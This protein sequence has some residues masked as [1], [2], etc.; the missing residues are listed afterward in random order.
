MEARARSSALPVALTVVAAVM[1]VVVVVLWN[2]PAE[3]LAASIASR[4]GG[5]ILLADAD[6]TIWSG[7]AVLAFGAPGGSAV[8]PARFALPGRITWTLETARMLAPVLHLKHDGVLR[9]PIAVHYA[10]GGLSI[11]PG[12]AV[13]PASLLEL[14]GP[15]LNTLR[16]EGRCIVHWQTLAIDGAGNAKGAGTLR[17]DG[18]ALALSPVRPL[19]DYLVDWTSDAQGLTWQLATETGPLE[20]VGNGH[21]GSGAASARATQARVVAR[22][23]ADAPVAVVAQLTPLLDMIGRHGTGEAV[24]ETGR[25]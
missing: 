2:A 23:A 20:L 3:W 13:L 21:V 10:N 7:S 12:T 22:T 9:E 17:V 1:C 4:T 14:I 25:P 8:A 24:I 19:G 5:V 15:P 16:P 11:D 6:G 18:F